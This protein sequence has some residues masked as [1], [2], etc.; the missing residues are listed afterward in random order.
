MR[1]CIVG[2][3]LAGALLAWRLAQAAPG[4]QIDLVLGRR[5]RAD[6][7]A[8]SGGAVRG[9][10]RDPEQRRLATAS[11]A[12]LLASP[13][14]RRWSRYRRVDSVYL[15]TGAPVDP[16]E[17]AEVERLLPGSVQPLSASG[18]ARLGWSEVHPDAVAVHEHRA[19]Y[20]APHR[21]REAVLADLAAHRRVRLRP[22]AVESFGT[23][24][25]GGVTCRTAGRT[26]AY[27]QLVVAAGAWTPRLLGSAGLPASGYRTKSIQYTIYRTGDWRPPMFVDEVIDLYGRPAADGELLLGL[28]T[29]QWGVDPDQPPVTPQLHEAAVT[30]AHTRFPK[31][32]LGP[33]VRTVAASD[34]YGTHPMSLRPVGDPGRR[35]FTFTGGAGGSVK[36]VL[37]A[38]REAAAPLASPESGTGDHSAPT[39]L[40]PREGL[41]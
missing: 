22:V 13:T 29:D 30:L 37:A 7:T 10:E 35:L 36:T 34:C 9:Y 32:R 12:E 5:C 3:G 20:L 26:D 31:L 39:P 14:L 24:A 41:P 28:P 15:P 27:D 2:G 23:T 1:T 4:H 8:A 33:A 18:L 19:G 21:L 6:A 17:L 25:G 40:G 16:A 11:L 38:T